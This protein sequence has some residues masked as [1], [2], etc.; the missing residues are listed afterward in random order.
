MQETDWGIRKK[1]E[2]WETFSEEAIDLLNICL[3]AKLKKNYDSEKGAGNVCR[4]IEEALEIV[5][6]EGEAKGKAEGEARLSSLINILCGKQQFEEVQKV[7]TD[8]E[9]RNQYYLKYNL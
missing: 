4:G 5:R 8:I 1:R 7:T 2:K 9:L 6:A 3:N